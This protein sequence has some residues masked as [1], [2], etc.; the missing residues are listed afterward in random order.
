[1][2]A[3]TGDMILWAVT[4]RGRMSFD[5]FASLWANVLRAAEFTGDESLQANSC[6]ATMRLLDALGHCETL[7]T[8]RSYGLVAARPCLTRLPRFG[9]PSAM[10]TGRRQPNTYDAIL[11]E[12]AKAGC[13]VHSGSFDCPGTLL[14]S[15]IELEADSV[16]RLQRTAY[17]LG[18]PYQAVPASLTMVSNTAS[19][20]DQLG[21]LQWLSAEEMNWSKSYFDPRLVVMSKRRFEGPL[22]LV[23]YENPYSH[24]VHFELRRG[25][26]RA[27]VDGEWGRFAMLR[28]YSKSVVIYDQRHRLLGNIASVPFPRLIRRAL[29]LSSGRPAK[30]GRLPSAHLDFPRRMVDVYENI[31]PNLAASVAQRVGQRI[32][33]IVN[34]SQIGE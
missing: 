29:T 33:L 14:P 7:R 18:I 16:D 8:E 13:I 10:L 4:A 11:D 9:A 3:M 1:M 12:A 31:S 17:A 19:L 26:Q 21:R 32:S 30:S 24:R 22:A 25:D 34:L 23:R 5:S 15:F 20:D 28:E 2:N 6:V 27:Q